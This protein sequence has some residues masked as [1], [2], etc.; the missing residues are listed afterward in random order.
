MNYD[1]A[2]TTSLTFSLS[3]SMIFSH[4]HFIYNHSTLMALKVQLVLLGQEQLVQ[5]VGQL[6]QEVGQLVQVGLAQVQEPEQ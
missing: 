1:I 5:E 3:T 2:Q 4:L 6:V